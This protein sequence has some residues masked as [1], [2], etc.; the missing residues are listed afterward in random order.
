MNVPENQ[1]SVTEEKKDS[2]PDFGVGKEV[3]GISSKGAR[4]VSVAWTIYQ[5]MKRNRDFVGILKLAQVHERFV[6]EKDFNSARLFEF[7]LAAVDALAQMG[8]VDDALGWL[9][10]IETRYGTSFR[11]NAAR[12]NVALIAGDISLTQEA[13]AA[14]LVAK[15]WKTFDNAKKWTDTK[16]SLH[17]AIRSNCAVIE[18]YEM[19]ALAFREQ[20]KTKFESKALAAVS[21]L[22]SGT[23]K[24]SLSRANNIHPDFGMGK[25]I[26]G[27]ALNGP[28]NVT[29]A[30]AIFEELKARNDATGIL[31]LAQA[32]DRFQRE[33]DLNSE[34]LFEF[35]MAAVGALKSLNR[36]EEALRWLGWLEQRYGSGFRIHAMRAVL[37]ADRNDIDTLQKASQAAITEPPTRPFLLAKK[38]IEAESEFLIATGQD[39]PVAEYYYMFAFALNEQEKKHQEHE[40]LKKAVA[41]NKHKIA[42]NVRL[43]ELSLLLKKWEDAENAYRNLIE[44]D[45]T[46]PDYYD[47]LARLLRRQGK[48]WQEVSAL[49]A[50]I[51]LDSTNAQW[52]FRL[53]EA[54]EVMNRLD[55]AAQA[56]KAAIALDDSDPNWHFKLGYVLQR[57]GHSAE[58][59]R[60]YDE[61][62]QKDSTKLSAKFGI[63]VFHQNRGNWTA[64]VQAYIAQT[65]ID[66][67]NAELFYRLGFA[68]DR[69]YAW[70]EAEA[71]YINAISLNINKVDWHYRLGFVR[72]RMGLWLKAAQAYAYAA[73]HGDKNVPD[74]HYRQGYVLYRAQCYEKACQAFFAVEKEKTLNA[75]RPQK[76]LGVVEGALSNTADL[77][78]ENPDVEYLYGFSKAN[79]I[80]HVLESDTTNA[81]WHYQLGNE[82]ERENDW[83]KAAEA[84]EAAIARKEDHNSL[85]YYRLGYVLTM[86]NR[87]KEACEAFIE[88]RIQKN[89]YG[90]SENLYA[91]NVDFKKVV[92][93]TEYYETLALQERIVLYE[94]YHGV[95]MSCNPYAIFLY[96]LELPEFADWTH[97]WVIQDKSK[98]PAKYRKLKNVLFVR[99][100]TD[101]YRRYLCTAKYLINNSTFPTYFIRRPDQVYLN[102]WHGTPLKA[103]GKDIKTTFMEHRNTARNFL[104][105]THLI[106][107]NP[108]TTH[109]LLDRYD[110]AGTFNGILAESGYPRIDLTLNQTDHEKSLMRKR[111]GIGAEKKVVLYA[112]TFRGALGAALQYASDLLVHDI[113][114]IENLNCHVLFRG[115][116]FVER[117]LNDSGIRH[118]VVPDDIDSNALLAIVDVLI[119]DYS[120][121][122][123]DFIATGKPI[124]YYV[125]DLDAFEQDR[126]LYFSI[127]QMPGMKCRTSEELVEAVARSFEQ[128]EATPE[129]RMAR[130]RFCLHEDGQAA[131]RVVDLVFFGKENATTIRDRDPRSSLLFFGGNFT[132]NGI[133]TSYLNLL[134][135]I[136]QHK[137]SLTIAVASDQIDAFPDRLEQFERLPNHVQ[138]IG[139]VGRMAMTLEEKW[140]IDTFNTQHALPSKEMWHVYEAAFRR[141]HV[142]IFGNTHFDASIQFEGYSRFWLAIFANA[143]AEMVSK[144][145]TYL[146][147]DMHGEWSLRFPHLTG[148][149]RLYKYF[150]SLISVSS[151]TSDHN[152]KNLSQ[153]FDIDKDLFDYCDNVQNPEELFARAEEQLE[154]PADA[155]L[156]QGD[157]PYF[158]TMGRLSVEKDHSK[159]IRA[160]ARVQADHPG[161]RLM[162]LGDG[163]L[164]H[165]LVNLIE[166]LNLQERV[167]LLG[168]RL[169]PFPY[170][171]RSDCFVLSSNHEGQP[172]V[173]F[174][175]M[176][177][178]KPI[179]ATDIVGSRSV[180][181]SRYG[182]LVD[183]SEEGLIS[184]MR[185]FSEGKLHAGEFD[186]RDYQ[187]NAVNMFYDK[188]ATIVDSSA[189]SV[190]NA[191]IAGKPARKRSSRNRS[192][193]ANP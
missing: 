61:A 77:P 2:H 26:E 25:N 109:V 3:E 110:I 140:M 151:K 107:P 150:D 72:E 145:V 181:E 86:L 178:G 153:L 155:Q 141:E 63:G 69:C 193:V 98:I 157:G 191:V 118:T 9:K 188:V 13:A 76:I 29:A 136:D 84:Y 116:Y 31:K 30:W 101:L 28:R 97:V 121:I 50:A 54:R 158:I 111:L 164:K 144:R 173:L 49:E 32:H 176:I 166:E 22:K 102:T 146:H 67:L 40:A 42:W 185:Q 14:A 168:R 38:W 106:S 81:D 36:I 55:G 82:Y 115:H 11:T 91:K 74:W 108:H 56:Y 114:M 122:A 189:A 163:P 126:G 92:D 105:A 167:Y 174:E 182:L 88:T 169:N 142:R 180:L 161:A 130:N 184:G 127:E 51:E 117:S 154:E 171:K 43:G 177:L 48:W 192:K 7:R 53:G 93:Y 68:H 23:F 65:A 16:N 66:P 100:D 73:T 131:R 138:V 71:A 186:Y 132:P 6:R 17:L 20:G 57:A 1:L 179:V 147:N 33:K 137:Y 103:M 149:F 129:S 133:S 165:A 125:H 113:S 156:F 112:P 41:L 47:Q 79:P 45:N 143:P 24:V 21:A 78:V 8:R 172:M 124:V 89:P 62:V 46:V 128:S 162:I 119:T 134:G 35:R 27:I 83:V 37:A 12:A 148:L 80:R 183:N 19:L 34:K 64:A 120:S 99:R 170:L 75:A 5:E 190:S 95:S 4:N 152:V 18:F 175:A 15:Q 123:F 10:W 90:A 160:F 94:S 139:R 70:P 187:V 59:Q 135:H 96:L 159:L 52:Y 87:H 39:C 85:W 104:H 60:A 58:S 44:Q